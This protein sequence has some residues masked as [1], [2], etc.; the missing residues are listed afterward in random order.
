MINQFDCNAG[1]SARLCCNSA[2]KL[3]SVKATK[4]KSNGEFKTPKKR[5]FSELLKIIKTHINYLMENDLN[6]ST[7][8]LN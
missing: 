5:V 7:V 8:K 1:T 3:K 4:H 6:Q 2:G